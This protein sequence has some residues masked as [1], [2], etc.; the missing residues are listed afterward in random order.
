M[1]TIIY[2]IGREDG[3][4]G[5]LTARHVV[6]DN[7]NEVLKELHYTHEHIKKQVKI[8]HGQLIPVEVEQTFIVKEK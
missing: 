4:P 8:F 7:L 1:Y 3:K 6:K 5:E 2:Y